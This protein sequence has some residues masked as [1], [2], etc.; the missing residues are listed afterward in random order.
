M[1]RV[2]WGI[3]ATT[4]DNFD[5]DSQYKPYDGP[6]PMN[7][8]YQ[9]RVKLLRYVPKTA[10]KLPQLRVGL[11]LVPREGR[12]E[13]RRISGFWI[14]AFLPV[15]DKTAFRYVP[16][17]D[18]IDVTGED[19][20]LRTST[21]TDGNITRIGQWRNDGKQLI[22]AELKDGQ[23]EKGNPRKEIGYMTYVPDDEEEDEEEDDEDYDDEDEYKDEGE[24]EP[25]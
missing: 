8:V 3:K 4:V 12:R 19:F 11:E 1:P 9:F 16:F 17:L 15:S 21:D 23:D 14:M 2:R 7:G 24:D 25:F 22:L 13:E 6:I 18:A 10:D 20:E 5:R